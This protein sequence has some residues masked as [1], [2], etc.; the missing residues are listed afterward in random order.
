MEK[1]SALWATV[2][3]NVAYLLVCLLVFVGLFVVAVLVERLWLAGSEA[4]ARNNAGL[5]VQLRFP[6]FHRRWLAEA[7]ELLCT[8]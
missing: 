8:A 5:P 3:E 1:L 6:F 2:Q 7:A 4:A